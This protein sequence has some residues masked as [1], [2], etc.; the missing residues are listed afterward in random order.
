MALP[1]GAKL[2][3]ASPALDVLTVSVNNEE[4]YGKLGSG[5]SLWYTLE[6][7]KSEMCTEIFPKDQLECL[8][9]AEYARWGW[10]NN[11]R[12]ESRFVKLIQRLKNI[13]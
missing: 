10:L 13:I 9:T 11:L 7:D 3:C 2:C 12:K 4:N 1:E 8:A 6:N 5:K